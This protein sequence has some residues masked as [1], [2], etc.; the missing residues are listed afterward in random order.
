MYFRLKIT[1]KSG[2]TSYS[3]ILAFQSAVETVSNNTLKVLNNPASDK[4]TLSFQSAAS[5]AVTIQLVDMTG[6]RVVQQQ[7]NSYPGNNITSLTLPSALNNGIYIVDLFDGV[8]HSTSRFV[9]Q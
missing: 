5:Q 4:L 2:A 6:R 8:S 1:E 3:K 7:V 9:K